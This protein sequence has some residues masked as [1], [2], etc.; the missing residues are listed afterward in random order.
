[1]K[2]EKCETTCEQK[3]V[4]KDQVDKIIRHHMYTAFGVGLIP[5]PLI[6]LVAVT[7]V[8]LNLVRKF[9]KIYGIPF[10]KDKV[11]SILTSLVGGAVPATAGA[12]VASLAKTVPVVGYSLGAISM[13]VI[14]SASTYAVGEV[15]NRHFASGGTFLTFDTEKVKNYYEKMFKKGKECASDINK[16]SYA[17]D[18]KYE[19]SVNTA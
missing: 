18:T 6:D 16:E 1:M 4:T 19:A 13:S 15:F 10:S 3:E 17:D 11:K 7:G 8:Q 12:P 2:E 14:A 9:A 5:M